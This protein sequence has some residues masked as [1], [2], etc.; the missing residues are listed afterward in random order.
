MYSTNEAGVVDWSFRV[1]CCAF[2]L[3]PVEKWKELNS[4]I[5]VRVD[6]IKGKDFVEFRKDRSSIRVVVHGVPQIQR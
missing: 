5:F 1:L 6:S 3:S 4:L 2:E